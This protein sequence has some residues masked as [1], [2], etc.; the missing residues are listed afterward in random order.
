MIQ[1]VIDP[2]EKK[3]DTARLYR[4]LGVSRSGV[5]AAASAAR[6]LAYNTHRL[7]STLGYRSPADYEKATT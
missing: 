6:V 3:A 2:W 4:L 1:Q 5:Y 7:H